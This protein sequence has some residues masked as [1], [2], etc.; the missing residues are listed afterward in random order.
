[1]SVS[2]SLHQSRHL[3]R[4][5]LVRKKLNKFG[6]NPND[7]LEITGTPI[8]LWFNVA[9][10][11]LLRGFVILLTWFGVI[12]EMTAIIQTLHLK[13]C[14]NI[15]YNTIIVLPKNLI[16]PPPPHIP[17]RNRSREFQNS[18]GDLERIFPN[19]TK[20]IWGLSC[21]KLRA[22][23]IFSGLDYILVYFDWLTWI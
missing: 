16:H 15:I 10:N 22:S 8:D 3:N 12:M 23:L 19:E 13:I 5:L 20:N 7:I 1:M 14:P 17:T 11:K 4:W 2:S 6:K 18:Q 21:T 9:G